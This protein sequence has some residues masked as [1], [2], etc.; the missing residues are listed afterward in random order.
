MKIGIFET[1][2]FEGAYP[3]IRLFDNGKNDITIFTYPHAYEQFQFLFAGELHK[4]RWIIKKEDES[5]RQFIGRMRRETKS[6]QLELLYLNTVTDNYISYYWMIRKLKPTR[7]IMTL[8]SI[9]NYFEHRFALNVRRMTRT[10]GKKKL[11]REVNEFN[12]V[13]MTMVNYLAERI[14][15]NKKVHCVP[16]AVYEGAGGVSRRQHEMRISKIVVPGTVD[17]RRRDYEAVIKLAEKLKND[18]IPIQLTILG[19]VHPLYGVE[20]INEIKKRNLGE[21]LRFYETEVVDQPEFDKV[22]DEADLV[23]LPSTINNTILDDIPE[24]YGLSMSSGN[25][26]DIIKHALPFLCPRK[27]RVD[28]F[29]ED[30][31]LRYDSPSEIIEIIMALNESPLVVSS[32]MTK[33][34]AAS[35]NYTV[36]AVRQRN[37]DLFL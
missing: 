20:I 11:I 5:K 21:K 8:H 13:A 28:P 17:H 24:I 9:N 14:P 7:I 23:L 27:L 2:H 30:S 19:G 32:L 16:G 1:T 4:F 35:A 22:M 10:V 29:L 33:A 31:C 12:V 3:V 25:L 37:T 6:L 36:E 26:F 15:A 18:D 34:K